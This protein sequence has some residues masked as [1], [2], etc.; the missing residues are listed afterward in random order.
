VE[1]L[2]T[3]D[4]QALSDFRFQLRKFLHFS[5]EVAR[6]ERL[7]PHQYQTLLAIKGLHDGDGPTIGRLADHLL[8]RHHSAVGLL[9]R[10]EERHLIKRVR[11]RYGDRRQVSIHLTREGEAK[12]KHLAA[13][14]RAELRTSGPAL[15]RTLQELLDRKYES[16]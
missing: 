9:D 11:A 6:A 8:I 14:H 3:S 1:D 4:Y 5:E 15:V 13:M 7:E 10:L 2:S 16:V 12:L